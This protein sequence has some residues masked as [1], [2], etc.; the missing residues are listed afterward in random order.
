[1]AV[2]GQ[3]I[4]VVKI[5][6]IQEWCKVLFCMK[7]MCSSFASYTH[8]GKEEVHTH[9]SCGRWRVLGLVH[10]QEFLPSLKH[11]KQ[12]DLKLTDFQQSRW[13]RVYLCPLGSRYQ[14]QWFLYWPDRIHSIAWFL[15]GTE[16]NIT[17]PVKSPWHMWCQTNRSIFLLHK[18]WCVPDIL[19][20]LWKHGWI[21]WTLSSL[22]T[23]SSGDRSKNVNITSDLEYCSGRFSEWVQFPNIRGFMKLL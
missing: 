1:M 12:S 18:N 19:I 22:S 15:K 21:L 6:A 14:T 9:T 4:A 3:I 8:P 20:G 2:Q 11:R 5:S 7:G 17:S 10:I 23:W 16:C 13:M